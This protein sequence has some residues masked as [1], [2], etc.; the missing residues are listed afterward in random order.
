MPCDISKGNA[1]GLNP[2]LL[3]LQPNVATVWT[4]DFTECNT[5]IMSF[6]AYV[7][8]PRTKSGQHSL[9]AN[10]P[11]QLT[12]TDVTTGQTYPGGGFIVD[13]SQP[14]SVGGH[15]IRLDLLHTG[16][17]PLDVEISYSA[18]L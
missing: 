3:T 12:G 4:W 11:L 6:V 2:I 16:N 17:H 8:K 9:P 18:V 13:F 14:G 10:T 1:G 7:T 15:V 5:P